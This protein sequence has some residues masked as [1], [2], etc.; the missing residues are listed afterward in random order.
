MALNSILLEKA[1]KIFKREGKFSRDLLR[2]ELKISDHHG[3]I[4]TEIFRNK[5][6][7]VKYLCK[8]CSVSKNIGTNIQ[9][10]FTSDNEQNII[11]TSSEI[12][13]LEELLT[14]CKVDLD[15]WEVIKHIVN[16][17]GSETNENFQV[18][19]WLKKKEE[20]I[21]ERDIKEIYESFVER[22]EK[23]APKYKI[24]HHKKQENNILEICTH[25]FHFG[26][27]SWGKETGY[28]DY[29]INIAKR[30]YTDSVDYFLSHGEGYK[31]E[32]IVFLVGSDWFNSN[33]AE[34]AT[35]RGTRQD[36]DSR[37]KKT[38]T[39]GHDLVVSAV[40]LCM[41][42][43][44]VD[45]IV[46]PGNHDTERSFYL[47][48]FLKAWYRNS[49]NVNIDNGPTTRKYYQYGYNLL[50]YTHGDK[51][52][53]DELPL[54]MAQE[55]S[56]MWGRTKNREM[57]TGHLHHKKKYI[58]MPIQEHQAVRVVQCPTLAAPDAWH[59]EKGYHSIREANGNVWNHENGNIANF[60]YLP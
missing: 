56:D 27:L 3:R 1:D 32:K 37:W 47:G 14:F 36:E 15:E 31:P 2:K 48:Q 49:K 13:T 45:V 10:E 18:K 24:V 50:G 41:A 12:R 44:N 17:W 20:D 21:L 4:L 26:Q 54:I 22:A 6:E 29:D 35:T 55:A 58:F 39:E 42:V 51:E 59:S 34:N 28:D 30:L 40:D 16:S 8:N 57:K 23:H 5:D 52:K 19:A 46:I 43:A 60:N 9:K 7:I 11:T 38:F 53:I 33:N 25:D